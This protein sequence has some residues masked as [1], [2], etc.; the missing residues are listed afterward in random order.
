MTTC[1]NCAKEFEGNYCPAC[2]QKAS[3]KRFSTK[4]LFSELIDKLLP[5]DRGVL[6]TA[7]H[8]LIRP[9]PMIR[10]Y[11]DGKRAKFTKPIQFLLIMVAI[12]L[13]FFSQEDF[14]QGMQRGIVDG[15][16]SEAANLFGQKFSN[17]IADNLTALVVGIIPFMAL[18]ANWF[19]KKR[20][21][22]YAEHFVINCFLI[23]GSTLAGMPFMLALKLMGQNAY[24]PHISALFGL[25]Y[26][27]YCIWGYVGFFKEHKAWNTGLKALMILL[28]GYLLYLL[29]AMILGAIGVLIYIKLFEGK[30]Q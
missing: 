4:I 14:K 18:F 6:Y 5:L 20:G 2:G 29:V 11:L 22:N 7:K 3:T 25:V 21:F 23:G 10:E 8:L 16:Q 26:V 15:S 13:I 12:S 27:V 9:G 1:K 28:L 24:S 30:M 17:W 19:Y